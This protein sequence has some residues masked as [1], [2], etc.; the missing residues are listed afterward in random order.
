M[1]G[2][3]A[4]S[5]CSAS[6]DVGEDVGRAAQDQV[7]DQPAHVRLRRV[8]ARRTGKAQTPVEPLVVEDEEQR[9][10]DQAARRPDAGDAL[11][12]EDVQGT[13]DRAERVVDQLLAE[14][15]LL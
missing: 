9:A 15:S 10:V 6:E 2:V 12:S 3:M 13:R 4:G 11:A 14:C 7:T 5:A 1:S 8:R